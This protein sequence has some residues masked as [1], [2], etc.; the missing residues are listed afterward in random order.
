MIVNVHM[1]DCRTVFQFASR[2]DLRQALKRDL[3]E[4]GAEQQRTVQAFV[5][6]QPGDLWTRLRVVKVRQGSIMYVV[7]AE[8][9]AVCADVDL[10]ARELRDERAAK[11]AASHAGE[12]SA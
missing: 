9:V 4:D 11:W 10:P 5:Q 3:G 1:A 7:N 8:D 2:A 6:W 12:V